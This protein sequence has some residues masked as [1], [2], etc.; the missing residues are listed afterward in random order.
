MFGF[1]LEFWGTK[2]FTSEEQF[3]D[4]I[5]LLIS[6]QKGLAKSELLSVTHMDPEELKLFIAIYRPFM[7]NFNDLWMIKNDTFKAAM[8]EKYN[9][10]P[11][12]MS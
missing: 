4:L 9:F 7:M 6:T 2:L 5:T 12:Q 1:T 8:I 11:A 3:K 10:S